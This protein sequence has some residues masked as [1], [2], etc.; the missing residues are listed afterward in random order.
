MGNSCGKGHIFNST[1]KK[2]EMLSLRMMGYSIVQLATKYNVDHTTIMYH[3]RQN[4]IA[5]KYKIREEL[6]RLLKAGEP[7]DEIS[8]KLDLIPEVIDLYIRVF[9]VD[10]N[11]IFARRKYKLKNIIVKKPKIEKIFK[12]RV[13]KGKTIETALSPPSTIIDK[14]GVEWLDTG[15]GR[16]I[17]VGR[18]E[19]SMKESLEKKKKKEL[20]LKRL[21]MLK[22]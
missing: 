19:E 18:T 1:E 9:G 16:R 17:C 10:G 12:I 3:C 2:E 13:K 14:N 7:V 6:Y 11:K 20:E 4:G 15:N 22:Y 21:Q 8:K 5:I